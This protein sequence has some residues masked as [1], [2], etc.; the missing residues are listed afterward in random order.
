MPNNKSRE[1]ILAEEALEELLSLSGKSKKPQR[2]GEILQKRDEIVTERMQGVRKNASKPTGLAAIIQNAR[3]NE[4][5][6]NEE[7]WADPD[8]AREKKIAKQLKA[9]NKSAY[10]SDVL[11]ER[12]LRRQA[13]KHS[14][15]N[16]ME[17]ILANYK[18]GNNNNDGE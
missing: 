9:N 16:P 3:Q 5:K 14:Y 7:M 15:E 10:D 2:L 13:E 6:V 17:G 4:E 11:R 8:L 12:I 18:N 1:D